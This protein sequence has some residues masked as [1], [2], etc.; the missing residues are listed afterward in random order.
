M[1]RRPIGHLS[2]LTMVAILVWARMVGEGW[3]PTQES[4]RIQVVD[5]PRPVAAAVEQIERHF[6][7]VVTY[8]DTR[9]VHPSDIVDVTAVVRRDGDMSRRVLGM[10]GGTIDVTYRPA[11][12]AATEAQVGEVLREV[13]AQSVAAGNT[14]EF[15]VERASGGHHVVPVAMKSTRGLMEPYQSPLDCRITVP[16]RTGS[17]LAAVLR[18]T[19]AI[20]A[21]SG[22]PVRP[23]VMPLNRL[24]QAQVAT[25]AEDEVARTALWRTLQAIDQRLSWQL[26]CGAGE[27]AICTLN[28]H[29]VRKQT[30][31]GDS[32]STR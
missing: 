2:T 10:R 31:L 14:G 4:L 28:I 29:F 21:R 8:E 17:G 13:L 5:Y 23:G 9:Y 20:A 25:G 11:A 15:R 26:L 30:V 18:I 3:A 27:D 1:S 22:L 19:E 6:G 16:G 24:E 12:G 7:W 32:P